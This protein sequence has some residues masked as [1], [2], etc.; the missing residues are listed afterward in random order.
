MVKIVDLVNE[1][2]LEMITKDVL[3]GPR[4]DRIFRAL[5]EFNVREN[6]FRRTV[7]GK[8]KKGVAEFTKKTREGDE[9]VKEL[10]GILML[11]HRRGIHTHSSGSIKYTTLDFS[12]LANKLVQESSSYTDSNGKRQPY[13]DGGYVVKE[14]EGDKLIISDKHIFHNYLTKALRECNRANPDR[15]LKNFSK[16]AQMLVP[17]DFSSSDGSSLT[18]GSKSL[19]ALAAG[20]SYVVKQTVFDGTEVGKVI[21]IGKG[22]EA[23]FFLYKIPKSELPKYA[24]LTPDSFFNPKEKVIGILRTYVPG[25]DK[26]VRNEYVVTPKDIAIS[27]DFIRKYVPAEAPVT[28]RPKSSRPLQL[29]ANY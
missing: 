3:I 11:K 24:R 14:N 15:K 12:G 9:R 7:A 8:T 18:I 16:L 1:G 20:D 10:I 29:A 25:L 6:Y 4:P 2:G 13:H 21:K 27:Q 17:K 28:L 23:E 5:V 26:S 19:M 22:V